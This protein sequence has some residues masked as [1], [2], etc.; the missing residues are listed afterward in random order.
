[1]NFRPQRSL[2]RSVAAIEKKFPEYQ[3]QP[4]LHRG[5]RQRIPHQREAQLPAQCAPT[6]AQYH[7]LRH[8]GEA[9][10]VR[11]DTIPK[12]CQKCSSKLSRRHMADR[13]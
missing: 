7:W 9:A 10:F 12:G 8:D 4:E 6:E 3:L 5:C 11:M 1:M 13:T 2:Y